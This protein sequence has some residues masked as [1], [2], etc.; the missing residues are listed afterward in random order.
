MS[1]KKLTIGTNSVE[2]VVFVKLSGVIDED[3]TLARTTKKLTGRT[4]VLDLAEVKRINSCG[5]RDW[6]NWLSDLHAKGKTVILTRCSPC[7]VT[8]LNL[9]N[10]FVGRAMV[11]A[12]YALGPP[13]LE[14]F[15]CVSVLSR[16]GVCRVTDRR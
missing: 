14:D 9:V 5:V 1:D 3:N 6:V 10:N 4:L 15:L 7:I 2:D 13:L 11:R 16:A 12:Y 8:Q